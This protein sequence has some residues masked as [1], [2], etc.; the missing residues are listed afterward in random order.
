MPNKSVFACY[1][2]CSI[3]YADVKTRKWFEITTITPKD[4]DLIISTTELGEPDI[5]FDMDASPK[6][7]CVDCNSSFTYAD[8]KY[9]RSPNSSIPKDGS[10]G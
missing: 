3:F 2:G 4:G 6:F 5:V 10:D 9:G 7:T 1:C 8:I